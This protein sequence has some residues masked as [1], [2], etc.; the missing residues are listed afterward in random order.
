MGPAVPLEVVQRVAAAVAAP[1]RSFD[2]ALREFGAALTS[3]GIN[4]EYTDTDELNILLSF[5]GFCILQSSSTKSSL[6]AV[7]LS[8]PALVDA[9][10]KRPPCR[11]EKLSYVSNN[12]PIEVVMDVGHNPAAI[13]ALVRRM[14][15]EYAGRHVHMIYAMSRDK[16]VRTCLRSIAKALP[17]DCIHFAQTQSWRAIPVDG[18]EA[19]FLEETGQQLPH[20]E[21]TC[22]ED[23]ITRVLNIA[24]DK[25]PN[26]VVI[27]CG[28]GFIMPP[29]R[30]ILG[31]VE[32]R[33]DVDLKR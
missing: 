12:V 8:S 9:L 28:T 6:K 24:A 31:I 14:Q 3:A 23:T 15:R 30:A 22:V 17:A 27:I 29:A 19:V 10:K 21:D 1:F 5:L 4:Q 7:P 33:D 2:N 25:G 32:P 18:L 16:D 20:C 11:W 26:S 13:E